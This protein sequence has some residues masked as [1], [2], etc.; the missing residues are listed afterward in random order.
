MALKEVYGPFPN[1]PP[2]TKV[3]KDMG[4]PVP[5]PSITGGAAGPSGASGGGSGIGVTYLGGL[6]VNSSPWLTYA[7]LGIIG[8]VALRIWKKK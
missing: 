5:I 6:R 4:S 7:V 8:L 1:L 2:E 3:Y